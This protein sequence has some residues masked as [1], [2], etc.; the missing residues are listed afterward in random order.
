M[1]IEWVFANSEEFWKSMKHGP[2]LKRA[3]TGLS[4][5]QH[6]VIRQEVV[7]RLDRFQRRGKLRIPNEAVLAVGRK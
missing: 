2:S 5:A 3:L 6:R 1:T 7:Q 4:P